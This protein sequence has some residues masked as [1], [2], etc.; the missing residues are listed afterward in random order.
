MNSVNDSVQK[1]LQNILYNIHVYPTYA[2]KIPYK[3]KR[4][5]SATTLNKANETRKAI[6]E[7][8]EK[9]F[10]DTGQLPPV[11][12][13]R[14]I[15][16]LKNS[17]NWLISSAKN[18]TVFSKSNGKSYSFKVNF[19]TL[20]IPTL[21]HNI[22]DAHFKSKLL[23]NFISAARYRFNMYNFVWKVETQ[24]NGNIHAHLTTDV[25]TDHKAVRAIWNKILQEHGV[26]DAYQKKHSGL[27][28]EQYVSMYVNDEQTNIVQLR[29]AYKNG[30]ESNW[31][32]PNS[33]DVHA[34]H[35]V[36]DL[37]AYLAKYFAKSD[38]DRRR[39]KGRVWSCSYS[40]S[41][42]NKL[43]LEEFS[44]I[45]Q[46][47]S[48]ELNNPA[49]KSK[50]IIVEN[51]VTGSKYVAGCI[52]F[53]KIADWG[54]VLRGSLFSEFNE[55]RWKIRNNL[56]NTYFIDETIEEYVYSEG[57]EPSIDLSDFVPIKA[58]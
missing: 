32:N 51:K 43:V 41:S 17:I 27:S 52:Y 58:N 21:D 3:D 36:K 30:V 7:Q 33:T 42:K 2:V 9:F 38:D 16:R 22:S 50:D 4:P 46:G 34:V 20:T 1:D 47:Y 40:L 54:K 31:K 56:S 29:K 19:I 26:I 15:S 10:A 49:V 25:F 18:K 48:N 35:K 37:G 14:A 28:E 13:T 53:Y 8:N 55:F 45:E 44:A 23:H 39:I 11:M 5:V 12:S 57:L 24:K 6:R